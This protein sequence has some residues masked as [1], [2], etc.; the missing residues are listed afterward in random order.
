MFHFTAIVTW[1]AILLHL[2]TLI[3][4]ARARATF[5]VKA[6]A[7]TGHPDFERVF[8]VQ[9]NML[10]WMRFS[11]LRCGCLPSTSAT[12]ARRQSASSGS[13]AASST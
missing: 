11:F 7:T 5:G 4:V 3:R 8:R 13:S 10:E 9:M 1:P 12:E 2:L 6:P